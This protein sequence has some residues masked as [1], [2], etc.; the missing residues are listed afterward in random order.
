MHCDCWSR[1]KVVRPIP[2]IL[3]TESLILLVDCHD[4]RTTDPVAVGNDC[5]ET[6]TEALQSL[7]VATV[8]SVGG[9]VSPRLDPASYDPGPVTESIAGWFR[10]FGGFFGGGRRSGH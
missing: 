1:G 3:T 2:A 8:S 6:S 7:P 5:A 10:F 9:A 4:Y